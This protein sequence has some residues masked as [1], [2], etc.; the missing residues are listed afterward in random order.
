MDSV[1]DT[2]VG[3]VAPFGYPRIKACSRLP[4]A[5]RSV[6]RPSSPPG[7]KAS[8]E[9]PYYAQSR[10]EPPRESGPS[11]HAQEPSTT[12]TA[13]HAG[14]RHSACT[15]GAHRHHD[16]QASTTPLNVVAIDRWQPTP[17][18]AAY[19]SDSRDRMTRPGT[20][21]NLI[22]SNKERQSRPNGTATIPLAP[23]PCGAW[24]ERHR[25]TKLL[26]DTP[27]MWRRQT[28]EIFWFFFSKKNTLL[29]CLAEKQRKPALLFEKRSKNFSFG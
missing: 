15:C 4:V 17:R 19:R 27:A 13:T 25:N 26:C 2:P 18:G 5:F 23:P 7:A 16:R 8:T 9:C 11:H 3:W 12:G 22:Y 6:P 21:Q 29:A 20:H 14:P 28:N 1:A 10:T 24:R